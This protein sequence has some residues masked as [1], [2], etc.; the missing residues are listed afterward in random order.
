[1]D[2]HRLALWCW[3]QQLRKESS[4]NF[5]HIDAHPDMADTAN[6]EFKIKNLDLW[7]MQLDV[8][9]NI[10]QEEFNL[11]LFRWDNYIPILLE[12]YP[13]LVS[14]ENTY[15]ATH[16]VGS[17]IELHHEVSSYKL[18]SELKNIFNGKKFIN[19]KKWI[20]NL[21]LDYFYSAQ[22]E[23]ILIYSNDFLSEIAY[24]LKM[25]I[26]Q[27]EI[28]VLTIALSPECCG[29]WEKSE[30]ILKIFNNILGIQCNLT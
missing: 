20:V 22:P 3:F 7:N 17:S 2:N 10:K 1:M 9:Q 14:R 24:S 21:D 27:N 23:K 16:K 13:N 12:H 15:S 26:E 28:S 5:F 29:S 19:G 4:Y 11:P 6:K 25:G 8:Y 30:E 18:L